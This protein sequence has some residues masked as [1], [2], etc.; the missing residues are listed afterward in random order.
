MEAKAKTRR[1]INDASEEQ[2]LSL[3]TA[4]YLQR[5]QV[6]TK[7][8]MS[9]QY[10]LAQSVVTVGNKEALT[11]KPL[12]MNLKLMMHSLSELAAWKSQK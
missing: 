9:F 12:I 11:T 1:R 8:M 10:V 5:H 6:N 2:K 4:H 3:K 7:L